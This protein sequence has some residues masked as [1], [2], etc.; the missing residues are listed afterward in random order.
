M[1]F[2]LDCSK[3]ASNVCDYGTEIQRGHHP[4][5]LVEGGEGDIN[6]ATVIDN[7][8]IVSSLGV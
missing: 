2:Y 7:V 8:H 5:H 6:D 4:M 1:H 3:L